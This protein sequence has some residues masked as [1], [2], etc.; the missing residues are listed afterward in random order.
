MPRNRCTPTRRNTPRDELYRRPQ[1]NN[2]GN[3]EDQQIAKLELPCALEC[4]L[5]RKYVVQLHLGI[6]YDRMCCFF[7]VV[8]PNKMRDTLIYIRDVLSTGYENDSLY[9]PTTAELG[10]A[11]SLAA[12]GFYRL[13]EK[14]IA[15]KLYQKSRQII[16]PVFDRVDTDLDV[17]GCFM[18]L[19]LYLVTTGQ[20]SQCEYFLSNAEHSVTL[21]KH[22]N[23]PT[24]C[25][26]VQ[27]LD[28]TLQS[29]RFQLDDHFNLFRLFLCT[30][31]FLQVFVDEFTDYTEALNLTNNSFLKNIDLVTHRIYSVYDKC[32]GILPSNDVGAKRLSVA[33]I[34]NGVKLLYLRQQG[35]LDVTCRVL[36]DTIADTY[37]SE[38]FGMVS[39]NM[40]LS[41]VEA[42]LVHTHLFLNQRN[43]ELR[44]KVELDLGALKKMSGTHWSVQKK[45]GS[46]IR[47]I[48]KLLNDNLID[49]TK[50]SLL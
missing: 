33:L 16:F 39:A 15:E 27:Y 48:E 12:N 10:F 45:F 43:E 34:A 7:P 35:H 50:L 5:M 38:Y 4:E 1:V 30:T 23:D 46:L 29:I 25:F 49:N 13:G 9:I 36:A 6:E 32:V 22:S 26:R 11:L 3:N 31:E 19:A 42:T 40:S 8:N 2:N 18:Y 20:I 21:M 17:A 37:N 24:V 14:H 47:T 44:R 41:I 28:M